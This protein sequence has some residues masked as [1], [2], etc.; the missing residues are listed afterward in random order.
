MPPGVSIFNQSIH[1]FRPQFCDYK[2]S[3]GLA[4]TNGGTNRYDEGVKILYASNTFHIRSRDLRVLGGFIPQ[5]PEAGLSYITY[6]ELVMGPRSA[7]SPETDVSSSLAEI[8]EDTLSRITKLMPKLQKLY[9]GFCPKTCLLKDCES[10]FKL[11]YECSRCQVGLVETTVRDLHQVGRSCEL[12]LGL[13]W[14]IYNQYL[15]EAQK[16]P[17]GRALKVGSPHWKPG[18][19]N[20]SWFPRF[21]I[22]MYVE[23]QRFES[24]SENE[25]SSGP[26]V[27]YWMSMSSFDIDERTMH[28]F[29]AEG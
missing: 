22:F 27:G 28:C 6:M 19:R 10:R 23:D 9:L 18:A 5:I 13:P 20:A 15:D 24:G 21:R 3:G 8:L 17:S 7:A 29:R 12:E 14:F 11:T 16:D 26:D 1:S 25:P 2:A 4:S